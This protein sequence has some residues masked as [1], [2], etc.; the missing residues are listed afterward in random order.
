LSIGQSPVCGLIHVKPLLPLNRSFRTVDVLGGFWHLANFF[1]P[2]AG[3]ALF[4]SLIA[5]LAWRRELSGVAW[6]RLWTWAFSGAALAG[7][8][9]LMIFGHDG[10]MATYAAMV[11][12]C[13]LGLWW[14]GFGAGR[15]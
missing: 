13:A 7:I 1:A 9:G 4:A 10:K 14:S 12:A 8:G 11:L 3:I 6:R 2:A 15:R 5:K